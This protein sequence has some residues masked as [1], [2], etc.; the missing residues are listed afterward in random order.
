MT[1]NRFLPL[2]LLTAAVFL[3]GC[4]D[5]TSPE[6]SP[7]ADLQDY[8]SSLPSWEAYSPP[9]P[10]TEAPLGDPVEDEEETMIDDEPYQCTTTPY[11]LTTTPDDIVTLNPDVEILWVG[12]L[13][14]GNGHLEGI[15]SLAEL[16][17]RQRA[18]VEVTLDLL[19]AENSRTVADPPVATVNAAIGGLI[20]DAAAAGHEAGSNIFYTSQATHSLDQAALKLGLSA[21]Y[22]GSTIKSSLSAEISAETRTVTAYYIQRMFTASMVLPQ[23]PEDVFSEAFTEAMLQREQES[24]RMG[25]DNPPVFVSSVAYGRIMMFSFTSTSSEAKI[26]ATLSALYNGGEF[27][28]TLETGLQEVLDN[29]EIRVVTVGGDAEHALDLIRENNL[30]AFFTSDAPLT[31]ARP[32][33]YTIRSLTDNVIARVSETTEYDLRQCARGTVTG[34]RY[35]ITADRIEADNLV[36]LYRWASVTYTAYLR[37]AVEGTRVAARRS[38]IVWMREGETHMMEGKPGEPLEVDVHFD[39]RD[40]IT[41]SGELND[42]Y[43]TPFSQYTFSRQFRWPTSTLGAGPGF[44]RVVAS[45]WLGNRWHLYFRYVK[46]Q[47]LFD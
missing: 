36:P 31:T 19:A 18:P 3:V 39:G 38:S 17:I 7:P 29:A 25:P 5:G 28:G 26:N 4:E 40:A 13:L 12:S 2:G 15:G 1:P 21:S 27:G 47:D 8:F 33:S 37:D 34:A 30:G 35:R 42:Y 16:P 22:M 46:V 11:S 20:E 44:A 32:I 43:W 41:V 10:E 24:G 9:L 45:D 23:H 14:Q 6:P